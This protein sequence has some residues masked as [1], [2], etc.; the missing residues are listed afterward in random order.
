[1]RTNSSGRPWW[2]LAKQGLSLLGV[3]VARPASVAVSARVHPLVVL[4]LRVALPGRG[5]RVGFGVLARYAFAGW[6]LECGVDDE[7]HLPGLLAAG[8]AACCAMNIASFGGR[9]N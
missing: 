2:R 9:I 7:A 3:P 8:L 1:M 4:I 6:A 5:T